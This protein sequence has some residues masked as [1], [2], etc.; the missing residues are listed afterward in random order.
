MKFSLLRFFRMESSVGI[1][2]ITATLFA[3]ILANSPLSNTYDYLIKLPV[4]ISAGELSISKPLLLWINDGLMAIFFFM[5]GLEIKRE[6]VEG[7]LKDTKKLVLPAFSAFG[8][9]LVP[10][11][12]YI[13][14]NFE[15]TGAMKGWAIPMATDI[16]F[17]LGILSLLGS[18][19][20][21]ELKL[22]LL[23]L[24]IIDDLGAII[25][26]AVFY[27]GSM[28]FIS[29]LFSISIIFLLFFM[30]IKGVKNLTAYILVGSIL[31]IAV[32]NSGVHAT[33]AGVILGLL[34][35][36]KN[37][38]KAFY[39]LENS[40]HTPVNFVILPIFAFANAGVC[41][42]G[43]GLKDVTDNMTLGIV[44]GLFL[45]KQIGIFVFAFLADKLGLG[46]LSKKISWINLYG[47]A[48]LSGVGFTMSLFVGS[49]AFECS[50]G[51]CFDLVDYRMGIL[52]GSLL[53]GV[54]GYFILSKT[55][56]N[57]K[58]KNAR[59]TRI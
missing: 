1:L 33:I 5:I 20:P 31:W 46:T 40:L 4:S 57:T 24:A 16:A 50:H 19:V 44:F 58:K 53:S 12:I 26:I 9:M 35:P 32:L 17:A 56:G 27:T 34:I 37:N 18:R 29:L 59:F 2:L 21:R 54:L 41:L 6:S 51:A 36:I 38:K 25:V 22:F 15:N 47:L 30:N 8:G 49:L 11:L 3:M 42:F 48:V 13:Y 45:G 28:S 14:F 55:L 10:A 7:S 52:I 23:T 39:F 43:I